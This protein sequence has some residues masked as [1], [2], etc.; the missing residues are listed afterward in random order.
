MFLAAAVTS[1]YFNF[2]LAADVLIDTLSVYKLYLGYVFSPAVI[3]LPYN[4][5][6]L[7][8]SSVLKPFYSIVAAKISSLIQ[9]K[10]YYLY[11]LLII[12]YILLNCSCLGF[13]LMGVDVIVIYL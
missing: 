13:V 10:T 1:Y 9:F 4:K 7:E 5:L 8:S 6:V 3:V 12:I 11:F 2:S